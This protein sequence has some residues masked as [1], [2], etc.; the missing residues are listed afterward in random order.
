MLKVIALSS[1]NLFLRYVIFQYSC[2]VFGNKYHNELAKQV[3]KSC[4]C[5]ILYCVV[6]QEC[7]T[8]TYMHFFLL[9][10]VKLN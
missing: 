8:C 3:L 7:L 6:L 4:F 9:L 5:Y 1:T 10:S 2:I